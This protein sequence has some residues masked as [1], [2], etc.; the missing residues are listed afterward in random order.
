[1]GKRGHR[2]MANIGAKR[3]CL[4]TGASG[5][6]GTV[7]CKEFGKSYEIVAVH[8]ETELD[9]STQNQWPIDPLRPD[10]SVDDVSVFA[11]QAD[12]TSDAQLQRVVELTLARFNRIDLLVNAAVH[13]V[14]SPILHT[15]TLLE[16][17]GSQ[18]RINVYVPLKLATLAAK[19]FWRVN[20]SE[21]RRIGRNIVNVSSMSA[22]EVYSG[23]GQAGYSATKA[24][25]N[26]LTRHMAVEFE[27]LGIRVN[28]ISPTRFPELI[29]TET[30]AREIIELD[31]APTTGEV[32]V[33]Q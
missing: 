10:T 33:V 4:L 25:L 32:R 15:E 26:Q 18:F 5:K 27:A 12:L 22:T 8:N 17:L 6:L 20:V 7:F 3:V 21:N 24:A 1:M 11:V 14:L 31:R 30:V 13:T 28:A 9:V 16:S 2:A 23:L 29:S 19:L